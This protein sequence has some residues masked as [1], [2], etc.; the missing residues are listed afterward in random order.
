MFTDALCHAALKKKG[1]VTLDN[2]D[3]VALADNHV[4]YIANTY[5]LE[6]PCRS[7]GSMAKEAYYATFA[8]APTIMTAWGRKFRR[9]ACG[10]APSA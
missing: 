6:D 4:C 10:T 3:V 5:P 7:A 1:V 2:I 9:R 8:M